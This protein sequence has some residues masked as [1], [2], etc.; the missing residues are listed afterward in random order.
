MPKKGMEA[1]GAF[2]SFNLSGKF[3]G[4]LGMLLW[5]K[6]KMQTKQAVCNSKK[7]PQKLALSKLFPE[8]YECHT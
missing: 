1:Q 4:Y 5:G 2:T 7:N 8:G 6:G 3:S